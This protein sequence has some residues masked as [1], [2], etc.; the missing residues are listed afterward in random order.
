[1]RR[2]VKL[3]VILIWVS[4]LLVAC[5]NKPRN[6]MYKITQS[7]EYE[8]TIFR[9]NCAICH[10]PEALG[11]TIDGKPVPSLRIGEPAKKSEE[12]IYRQIADGKLPMPSFRNQLTED[13]IR[14]M[15]KFVK[16][17]IQGRSGEQDKE[18]VSDKEE[19]VTEDK[20]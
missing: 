7:D 8:A 17:K 15:A 16:E 19:K 18:S 4:M 1:M 9:Q 12:E 3:I 11:K 5:T 14:R 2:S 20:N 10:G 6:R 13:E